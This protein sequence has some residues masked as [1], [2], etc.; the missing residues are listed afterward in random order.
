MAP[1]RNVTTAGIC[2]S[3]SDSWYYNHFETY[4]VN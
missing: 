1:V 2:C 3:G 4:C